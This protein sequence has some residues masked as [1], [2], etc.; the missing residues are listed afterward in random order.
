MDILSAK[1]GL[2]F[3]GLISAVVVL[4]ASVPLWAEG[5]GSAIT[6]AVVAG[7]AILSVLCLWGAWRYDPVSFARF[8]AV[9]SLLSGLFAIIL[10]W[11]WDR[12][13]VGAV[14]V[15]ALSAVVGI[16]IG[17]WLWRY[18][19]ADDPVPDVLS[20]LFDRSLIMER[21]DI[22][23]VYALSEARLSPLGAT[24][25][26]I[27]LQNCCAG[28]RRVEAKLRT[29]R[30]GWKRPRGSLRLPPSESFELGGGEAGYLS[31]PVQASEDADG[32]F[33]VVLELHVRGSR[34]ARIRKWRAPALPTHYPW[35]FSIL[36]LAGGQLLIGG[37]A[38][39]RIEVAADG[40]PGDADVT[41]GS[42]WHALF[43][44]AE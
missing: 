6:L 22:Q 19:H 35:W 9:A 23:I 42:R 33:D 31:V 17:R 8:A 32:A 41:A 18:H 11:Q 38:K 30:A 7:A 15:L 5:D 14:V 36:A 29:R 13:L 25:L 12:I 28:P 10:L 24:E 1:F 43:T 26:Q 21:L 2:Y 37:G 44:G 40:S 16:G 39:A 34:G 20:E 27:Y 3:V 4:A